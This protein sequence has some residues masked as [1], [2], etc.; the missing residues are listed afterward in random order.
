MQRGCAEG[1]ATMTVVSP[2]L[3]GGPAFSGTTLLALLCTQPGM[4]CLDEPDFEDPAQ[5]HR[6]Y[7]DLA[8]HFPDADLPEPRPCGDRW[9]AYQLVRDCA[10]AVRPSA[11]GIKTCDR[12]FLELAEHFRRDGLPVVMIVRDIRDALARPLPP[13]TTEES[14]NEA[15][16]LA[17]AHRDRV[18]AWI[19]YEDLVREPASVLARVASALGY[20]GV[21]RTTWTADAVPGT[22]LKLDRH[23]ALRR[24]RIVTDRLGIGR[25]DS[26]PETSQT[27]R[28]MGYPA[29]PAGRT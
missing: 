24:G 16:R 28:M 21:M 14:L 22:M 13:W 5:C 6:G 9:A 12:R 7:A 18:T 19:R 25:D 23:D 17:W 26:S 2:F 8:R 3:V 20:P 27:A 10:V 11:L 29:R 4:V 1:N 15:Y